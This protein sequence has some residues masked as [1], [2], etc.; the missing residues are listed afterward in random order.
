MGNASNASVEE[1]TKEYGFILANGEAIEV[2]YKLVRD[3]LIFTKQRLILVDKQGIT[4]KKIEF[5][6]IPYRS[7]TAFAVET[8]GHLDFDA[9][10]R[11]WV[12]AYQQPIIKKFNKSVNIYEVQAILADAIVGT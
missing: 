8:A 4:G 6:S 12:S 5:L 9:E 10:L 2:A 11:I 1:I 7:I 3:C